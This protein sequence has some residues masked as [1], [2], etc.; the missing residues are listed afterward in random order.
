MTGHPK[1]NSP[2]WQEPMV[3]KSHQEQPPNRGLLGGRGQRSLS[4]EGEGRLHRVLGADIRLWLVNFIGAQ[5]PPTRRTADLCV[6]TRM[7]DVLD[8]DLHL[9]WKKYG[10]S[11]AKSQ[12]LGRTRTENKGKSSPVRAMTQYNAPE[13]N[14]SPWTQLRDEE[15]QADGKRQWHGTGK[16][17]K[18]A[19]SSKLRLWDL[20]ASQRLEGEGK[21]AKKPK[22]VQRR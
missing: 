9:G 20:M 3:L 6:P 12:F 14:A 10:E 4:R 16:G 18:S 17:W 21:T 11:R 13:A 22:Q 5:F 1:A 2:R 15:P 19:L 7:C 8:G